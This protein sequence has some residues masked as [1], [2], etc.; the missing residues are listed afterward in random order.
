MRKRRANLSFERFEDRRLFAVDLAPGLIQCGAMTQ[1]DPCEIACVAQESTPESEILTPVQD[2]IETEV[3]PVLV[4]TLDLSDGADGFLGELTEDHTSEQ[5]TFSTPAAGHVEIAVASTVEEWMTV[6]VSDSDGNLVSEL[7]SEDVDGIQVL[8]FDVEAEGSYDVRISTTAEGEGRFQLTATHHEA[9]VEDLHAD[10]MGP[11]ATLLE[12]D[13][14]SIELT[15]ELEKPGDVDTFRFTSPETGQAELF[16]G[17]VSESTDMDLDIQVFDDSGAL[18]TDGATNEIVMLSFDVEADREYFV[19]LSAGEDQQGA[20]SFL[21]NV[22]AN[23]PELGEENSQTEETEADVQSNLSTG[24]DIQADP[25]C[26][27]TAESVVEDE[28]SEST[29][30]EQDSV[31]ISIDAT[32]DAS[33]EVNSNAAAYELAVDIPDQV[34]FRVSGEWTLDAT[35]NGE[36]ESE[37]CDELAG[38]SDLLEEEVSEP[39][40]CGLAEVDQVFASLEQESDPSPFHAWADRLSDR[41]GRWTVWS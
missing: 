2:S 24:S 36:N 17:D 35:R 7:G 1:P 14:G 41:L 9:I 4:R 37:S 8:T 40:P 28:E 12:F 3:E 25:E 30:D 6:E 11:D 18:V 34:I 33:M 29:M 22:Q 38:S 5:F 16:V 21:M 19:S 26:A 23:S 15:G 32:L 39:E 10:E 27:T 20:Y 13:D 31:A